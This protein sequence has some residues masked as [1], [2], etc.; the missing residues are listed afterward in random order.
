MLVAAAPAPDDRAQPAP[1]RMSRPTSDS[2][3][4]Q[5][6]AAFL[7]I[8]C[9]ITLAF[10]AFHRHQYEGARS[11]VAATLESTAALRAGEV[12]R[13]RGERLGDGE[14]LRRNR[15]ALGTLETWMAGRAPG[16]GAYVRHWLA[17]YLEAHAYESVQILNVRD[18]ALFVAG[19]ALLVSDAT[20]ELIG[21]AR[22]QGR[23]LLGDIQRD[24]DGRPYLDMV[25]PVPLADEYWVIGTVILRIDPERTLYPLLRSWPG[26]S[27]SAEILL[28]AERDDGLHFLAPP[29]GAGPGEPWPVVAREDTELVSAA[30]ARGA[31]EAAGVDYRRGPRVLA[32]GARVAG[33]DWLLVGKIDEDEVREAVRRQT[34]VAAAGGVV[35]VLLAA[36]LLARI[37][38]RQRRAAQRR[39]EA[40]LRDRRE[41]ERLRNHLHDALEVAQLGSWDRNLETGELWWSHETRALLQ[42]PA[43]ETPT[44]SGFLARIHPEDRER[45]A[46][47]THEAYTAGR[48]FE[49]GYRALL[50][51]GT[52]RHFHNRVRVVRDN[53]GR[54][55]RAIGTVQDVTAQRALERELQ[56]QGAYLLAIVNHLPQGISVFDENLR[57]QY[58]N[59]RL[60][61]VLEL[62]PELLYRG[63]DFDELIMV[64]AR[65]G[66]YGPGD[67]A[68]QVRER[69][70]LA[71]EFRPHR[72]ERTRPN[73]AT[74]L[75]AGEPLF[76]DGQVAGFIT[77]YTDITESKRVERELE[78]RHRLLQTIIDHIPGGV[79]LIDGELRLVTWN[80]ELKRLLDLPDRL[81]ADGPPF[82]GDILQFNAERGE[83]GPG[84]PAAI[85]AELLARARN[86]VAHGFERVRPD[87]QVLHVQGQPLPD[88]G[89][90]TIY[91]DVTEQRRAEKRLLLADTVFE[92]SPE[93]IVVT[94]LAR[95]IVSVNPAHETITGL[96]PERA[97][98]TLFRPEE[99]DGAEPGEIDAATIWAIVERHGTFAGE[100]RGR[101]ADG[102][103]YPR[104]LMLNAVR[105]G[106]TR[107]VT[108]YLAIFSDITDRKRSEADIRHLAHHDTL[109]GLANRFS[110]GARLEQSVADARRNGQQLAVLFLDLDRFKNINDSLG[111]HVGDALLV[112]VAQRL[113]AAVR[114]TDTVARLGGDEFVV[115]L[116]GI[117]GS[118]DAAHVAGKLLAA[119]SAPYPVQG[120][121]LHTTPSIGISLFPSDS[122]APATLLRNADTAMYHAKAVGRANYQFYTEE[123]NRVATA[124]LALEG[125]LRQA[126][127][128]REFE[129][130]YQPQF[131]SGDGSLTGLEAL[132][133]WRHPEDGLIAP[134]QFIPLAEETGIIM[135]IGTWVLGEA[136]RQARRWLD[137]GLPPLRMSVNLSV[138]QLRDAYLADTVASVLAGTGLRPE[139][140]ELEITESS[141]MDRP[142]KAIAVLETLKR[143]G[144]KIAIDD[145]GTGHSSLSYLKLFPL[146]HLKIDRSFVSDIEHDA[147]DAAIVAAAVS[148][149]HSL[150]LSV[151][152]EGVETAVQVERLRT[153]GCDELQGYHFSRP[154]PAAE[155]ERFIRTRLALPA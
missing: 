114:E 56:R 144:V 31:G 28:L 46:T 14:V 55:V 118:T 9:L 69:R 139:L 125:K 107:Q 111:H 13:W 23:P 128:R 60:G 93:A 27:A 59:A 24:E 85:T 32:A 21:Q 43:D 37:W 141:V 155:M 5:F 112:Q 81:F 123:M 11:A 71:L 143:L 137:A 146:D 120:H 122:E 133:R 95:R 61:D 110:L 40:E 132:V 2:Y 64:P 62:P 73:G 138:R 19:G 74:H 44:L 153:L 38:R 151:V 106:Y 45:V 8:A 26:A 42:I 87:G 36:A 108:H 100:C 121:E 116:P 33:S 39:L 34:S 113:L 102:E 134:A 83:Y 104:W 65:R 117:G 50:P 119:L 145:F 127:A 35:V 25:I 68:E 98:G 48:D 103:T 142:D 7:L 90:V 79:S 63:V 78:R 105:D 22:E 150:G 16:A 80:E 86:P 89:F 97:L 92:N 147:N 51:D 91:T 148:L 12:E 131:A 140:L 109:T 52:L 72:F 30:I 49:A 66:E 29:R 96:T 53:Q 124:R 57:L 6:L 129:L 70:R 136:C 75:V 20:R 154:L 149:A 88:G 126:L 10:V 58:W 76:I 17:G 99:G 115:V 18:E 84:D 130:W 4:P 67:P 94:D 82:L 77:T 152:A 3:G 15:A 101:R 47:L 1:R 41:L 135:E 54:P